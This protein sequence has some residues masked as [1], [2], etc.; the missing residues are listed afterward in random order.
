MSSCAVCV[1]LLLGGHI[2]LVASSI[3]DDGGAEATCDSGGTC[4]STDSDVLFEMLLEKPTEF[5]PSSLPDI[6]L[7]VRRW[8][9]EEVKSLLIVHHGGCR[10]HSGWY[11][12]LGKRLVED[13]IGVIAYDMVG[14]GF[15]GG[16]EGRRQYFDSI[17]T[18]SDDLMKF[19]KDTR[20]KFPGKRVFVLGESFG[21]MIAF[22]N[23]LREQKNNAAADGYIMTGPV[24]TLRDEML[25][26]KIVLV[27]D[28]LLARFF[29]KLKMPGT[30]LYS[31]FDEAFGDPRWA[32]AERADPF[33]Q[34]AFVTPPLLDMVV[35][36][37][38]VS[39]SNKKSMDQVEVP[40]FF[41]VGASDVR[42][43]IPESELFVELARSKDK[44]LKIVDNARH[45]LFQDQREI[46][47]EVIEDTKEWILA[48]SV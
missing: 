21:G 27:V 46:T 34:E 16:I 12:Q 25:P 15:S 23:I 9:P 39:E 48:R 33:V 47:N 8:I 38:A 44:R 13:G 31:T 4:S 5:V 11:V 3:D 32:Q 24:I 45:L 18:L 41:L 42:I 36:T 20:E 22:H 28:K 43:N 19:V 17:D 7:A 30:D 40:L 10:Q 2:G 29:P 35:S 1:A 6:R 26:P 37:L 14:S